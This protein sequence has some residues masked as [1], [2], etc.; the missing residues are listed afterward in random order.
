MINS[1]LKRHFSLYKHPTRDGNK[2]STKKHWSIIV[3]IHKTYLCEYSDKQLSKS[4]SLNK[5]CQ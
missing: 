4:D 5:T 1:N 3:N 2:K